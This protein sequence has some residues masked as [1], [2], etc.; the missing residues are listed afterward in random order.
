MAFPYDDFT[1][2]YV[3]TLQNLAL[4]AVPHHEERVERLVEDALAHDAVFC[5]LV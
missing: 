4:H 5:D 3:M 2:P 1:T